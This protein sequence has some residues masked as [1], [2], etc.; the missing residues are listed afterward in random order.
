MTAWPLANHAHLSF[1][2][3]L[4]SSF[5]SFSVFSSTPVTFPLLPPHCMPRP[6]L[7]R[8]ASCSWSNTP[9]CGWSNG[10]KSGV[11]VRF[12]PLQPAT[13][14]WIQSAWNQRHSA[15]VVNAAYFRGGS[16]LTVIDHSLQSLCVV[17]FLYGN[18]CLKKTINDYWQHT[19]VNYTFSQCR[20]IQKHWILV[21][22]RF[23]SFL[24]TNSNCMCAER[25]LVWDFLDSDIKGVFFLQLFS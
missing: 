13:A 15:V 3:L 2:L 14:S 6:A 1:P 18:E 5:P 8:S 7:T 11:S 20:K 4:P 19:M 9:C 21:K 25:F 16:L 23:I 10:T 17:C 12:G 24:L 22:Y